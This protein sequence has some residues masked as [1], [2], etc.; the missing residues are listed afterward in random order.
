M[1]GASAGLRRGNRLLTGFFYC[2]DG[3]V[4]LFSRV[5][6]CDAGGS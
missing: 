1:G 2:V 5:I 3:I 4:Y 6:V